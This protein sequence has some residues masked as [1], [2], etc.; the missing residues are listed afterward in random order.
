[1]PLPQRRGVDQPEGGQRRAEREKDV[2]HI[3]VQAQRKPPTAAG[4]AARSLGQRTGGC[5]ATGLVVRTAGA[6][7]VRLPDAH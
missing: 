4:N 6:G 5:E 2:R 3:A 1:M 7:M